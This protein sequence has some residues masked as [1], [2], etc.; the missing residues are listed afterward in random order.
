M[1]TL[2]ARC[3]LCMFGR[4]LFIILFC[5]IALGI[6]SVSIGTPAL[7]E[8][9][10]AQSQST[11]VSLPPMQEELTTETWGIF[12]P[13]TGAIIAGHNIDA[14]R[15]IASITKLFTA[16][17]VMQSDKKNTD[18]FIT[19]TDVSTEGR[20][21]KLYV[22]EHMTL[23]TLLF[24]LLI[25][26]SNDSAT[27]IQRTLGNAFSHSVSEILKE[28]ALNKTSLA[29]PSGLSVKNIST[30]SDLAVFFSYIKKTYPH[31]L[32]I[33]QLDVYV[34]VSDGYVNNNPARTLKNFT[35]GKQGYTEEAKHTFIGTFVLPHTSKEIG[36]VLLSS[37]DVLH[38]VRGLLAYS[39]Q[40]G[41]SF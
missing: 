25:E 22:G 4:I 11:T 14:Q 39:E 3:V 35:G 2:L 41:N 28:Q 13:S 29:D 34:G 32:D 15:P 12:D 27:A 17:V 20:S 1:L 24:P 33:T 23:Y 36:I 8:Y 21:G 7:S 19:H 30:I 18:V 5:S 38:D 6:F 10:T 16:T 31:L 37:E 26:S 9:F 40:V